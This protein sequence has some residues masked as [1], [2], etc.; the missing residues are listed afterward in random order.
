VLHLF[1]EYYHPLVVK[2]TVVIIPEKTSANNPKNTNPIT[3]NPNPKNTI[4]PKTKENQIKHKE[5][6][7]KHKENT[8]KYQLKN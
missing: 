4:N 2:F 6:Q 5:N 7:T 8:N 3:A 1:G